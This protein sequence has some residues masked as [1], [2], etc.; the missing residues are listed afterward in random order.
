M[1][2]WELNSLARVLPPFWSTGG[3]QLRIMRRLFDESDMSE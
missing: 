2:Y 3:M 1:L